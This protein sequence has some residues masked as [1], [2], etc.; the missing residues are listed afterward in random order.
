MIPHEVE[1]SNGNNEH[2]PKQLMVPSSFQT[3]RVFVEAQDVVN[4]MSIRLIKNGSAENFHIINP[5]SLSIEYILR[6][7]PEDLPKQRASVEQGADFISVS[8]CR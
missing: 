5:S 7:R 4:A 3:C 1:F 2:L 6:A 8:G